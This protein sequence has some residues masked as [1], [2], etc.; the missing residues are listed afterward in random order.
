MSV[1]TNGH[2]PPQQSGSSEF[3]QGL[4]AQPSEPTSLRPQPSNP[5]SPQS[6]LPSS[7]QA[8]Q[9]SLFRN[10]PRL[11]Q[12]H[13]IFFES[14]FVRQNADVI[15]QGSHSPITGLPRQTLESS[16]PRGVGGRGQK[17]RRRSPR[18][19]GTG[20]KALAVSFLTI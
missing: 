3:L 4:P 7:P 18:R 2:K 15:R 14:H 10:K 12:H 20:E 16:Y 5:P 19:R 8:N 1:S 6:T 9:P 11:T 17:A 13:D